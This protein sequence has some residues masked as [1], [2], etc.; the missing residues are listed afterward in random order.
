MTQLW[1]NSNNTETLNPMEKKPL[2]VLLFN[3]G[4]ATGID[5]S[6]RSYLLRWYRYIYTPRA[7][8]CKVRNS[9]YALL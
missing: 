4:Y 7:I 6:M 5:G 2:R 9:I 1:Y 3:L 8:I